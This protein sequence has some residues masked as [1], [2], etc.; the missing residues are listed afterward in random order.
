MEVWGVRVTE[1]K[2]SMD[3]RRLTE[4]QV[5]GFLEEDFNRNRPQ[6]QL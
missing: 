4:A 2:D 1:D 5:V 6:Q 3:V